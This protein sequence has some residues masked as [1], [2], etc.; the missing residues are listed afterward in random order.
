MCNKSR[1]EV[2]HSS[3]EGVRKS[4]GQGDGK[5]IAI[6]EF[7]IN[8]EKTV[9]LNLRD[10]VPDGVIGIT[11]DDGGCKLC[12]S[13][14]TEI[15]NGKVFGPHKDV[16]FGCRRDDEMFE[17]TVH[18]CEVVVAVEEHFRQMVQGHS[19]EGRAQRKWIDVLVEVEFHVLKI[20]N[21]NK[22]LQKAIERKNVVD[23]LV[24]VKITEA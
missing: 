9:A 11:A 19:L 16:H 15:Y 7:G 8:T 24:L 6:H 14:V 5:N 20:W 23:A 1:G 2:V 22:H 21:L 17:N 18:V 13:R 12:E 4:V 3:E 10:G